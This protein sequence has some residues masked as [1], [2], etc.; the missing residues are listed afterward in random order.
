MAVGMAAAA[1][2]GIE[3]SASVRDDSFRD[4]ETNVIFIITHI[5]VM[6]SRTNLGNLVNSAFARVFS[7]T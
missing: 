5:Y 4:S 3:V 7:D 1:L 6:L 2:A